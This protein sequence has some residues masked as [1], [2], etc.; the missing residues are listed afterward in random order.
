MLKQRPS[1]RA[2]A[3]I[4]VVATT[5]TSC[6]S[7]SSNSSSVSSVSTGAGQIA[8]QIRQTFN[9]LPTSVHVTNVSYASGTATVTTSLSATSVDKAI[10]GTACS[11]ITGAGI[12]RIRHAQ[13]RASDGSVIA[14]C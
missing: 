13:I 1:A 12:G 4:V 7:S 14:R 11:A 6:G 3:L 10:A 8:A 9:S 5:L 2:V